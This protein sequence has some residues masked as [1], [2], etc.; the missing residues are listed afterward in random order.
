[1]SET[2]DAP[3]SEAADSSHDASHMHALPHDN[4]DS[5]DNAAA[6]GEADGQPAAADIA[7]AVGE[8]DGQPAAADIDNS[9]AMLQL[10]EDAAGGQQS[11]GGE[12]SGEQEGSVSAAA[13][14]DEPS[15]SPAQSLI[16]SV[17]AADA[18]P[19][20]EHTAA[21]AIEEP[22]SAATANKENAAV[23]RS[24]GDIEF[25]KLIGCKFR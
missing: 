7:A 9:S 24:S 5:G 15:H 4:R 13:D 17:A 25:T 16:H 10:T 3:P 18:Q 6:V 23:S 22:A 20:I 21:A 1:M 14:A 12:T 19:T 11:A 8:A 2:L